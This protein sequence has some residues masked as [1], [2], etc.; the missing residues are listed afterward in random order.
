MPRAVV[1]VALRLLS[2]AL[3]VG[4]VAL[5]GFVIVDL[6]AVIGLGGKISWAGYALLLPLTS[7]VP[8]LLAIAVWKAANHVRRGGPS[9]I[10]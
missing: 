3:L 2:I 5:T 4:A 6:A 8:A 1:A 9:S 7:V 10:R